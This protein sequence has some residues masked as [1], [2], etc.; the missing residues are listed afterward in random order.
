[1]TVATPQS[2]TQLR[3]FRDSYGPVACR[4]VESAAD[5]AIGWMTV[6]GPF[7][8]ADT[9]NGNGRLYPS[10]LWERILNDRS[11]QERV[12]TRAMI[13]VVEHPADG[14][15]R[16]LE[17]SHVVTRL[18]REGNVIMGEAIVFNTPAGNVV[19]NLLR[20]GCPVGISSRGRGTS[21]REGGV[22]VVCESDFILDTFDFVAQPS[23]PGAFVN[24]KLHE[25][26]HGPYSTEA[27]PVDRNI[28]LRRIDVTL[29]DLLGEA[30]TA[31]QARLLVIDRTLLETSARIRGLRGPGTE[32]YADS[33]LERLAPVRKRV[34]ERLDEMMSVTPAAAA[35]ATPKNERTNAPQGETR[36]SYWHRRFL[37]ERARQVHEADESAVTRLTAANRQLREQLTGE[38][39]AHQATRLRLDKSMKLLEGLLARHDRSAIVRA[40]SEAIKQHPT[41]AGSADRL[42]KLPNVRS[43]KERV[44][45]LLAAQA[46][47]TP[48]DEGMTRLY[49]EQG[50]GAK[51]PGQQPAPATRQEE[52]ARSGSVGG[53]KRRINISESEVRTAVTDTDRK[54][55]ESAKP[56]PQAT[57]GP[58]LLFKHMRARK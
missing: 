46:E 20:A 9:P 28:E 27:Q 56:A 49:E 35:E 16:L 47:V 2:S 14:Q 45:E 19:Q 38:R 1:M 43:V 3:E 18:W 42:R 50:A 6:Q 26:L 53:A 13:G 51:K 22:D 31:D 57:T 54:L 24:P 55:A 34:T 36:E 52:K 44:E 5:N 37:E 15:T 29:H 48:L 30:S 12:K 40:V 8:K 25:A 58:A 7:Q 32:E 39:G 33:L 4:I 23:T 10:A 17:A 11:F 21:R 41:L